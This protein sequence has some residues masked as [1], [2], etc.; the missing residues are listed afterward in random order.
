MGLSGSDRK[1][2]EAYDNVIRHIPGFG[3]LYSLLRAA[4]YG[5]KNNNEEAEWSGKNAA[6]PIWGY[7]ERDIPEKFK[8]MA[9]NKVEQLKTGAKAKVKE[10]A[11]ENAGLIVAVTATVV[12]AVWGLWSWSSRRKVSYKRR[13]ISPFWYIDVSR[14]PQRSALARRERV[15]SSEKNLS[16]PIEVVYCNVDLTHNGLPVSGVCGV[17]FLSL[18][19]E[20]DRFVMIFRPCRTALRY[21]IPNKLCN[22]NF[23]PGLNFS[24]NNQSTALF[25]YL[26]DYS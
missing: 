20:G 12:V 26:A 15:R 1:E 4:V 16:E 18:R 23:H 24:P 7:A 5:G 8:Q 3:G 2:K 9:Q 21:M 19:E 25:E 14:S 11:T 10:K 13:L 17:W 6:S 22:T